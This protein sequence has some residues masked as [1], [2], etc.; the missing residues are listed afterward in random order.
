MLKIP[1]YLP[2]ATNNIFRWRNNPRI[3]ILIILLFILLWEFLN[4]IIAFS[5]AVGY[6]VTPWLF[7]FLSSFAYT[8][9]IMMFGILLLFCDA[10]FAHEGQ[11]Y[12][13]IRSGRTHWFWGQ[14]LYIMISTA[15]Y[16]LFINLLIW[17]ILSPNLVYTNDWGKVLRTLAQTSAGQE[18]RIILPFDSGIQLNYSPMQAFFTSFFMEWLVGVTLGLIV[19]IVNLYCNRHALGAAAGAAVVLLDIVVYNDLSDFIYHFSPVSMARL[20]IIDTTGL[21][22]RPTMLYSVL[23][24][25][26]MIII[27]ALI[28]VQTVRKREIRITRSI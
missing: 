14:F 27:L 8:Q 7:P 2:I 13:M 9:R 22:M 24:C 17:L 19:F 23:F 11:P 4:P 26:C 28:A 6:R 5:N 20:T 3:Y 15:I 12:L 21:S 10:P 18:F 1:S 25:F 16:F